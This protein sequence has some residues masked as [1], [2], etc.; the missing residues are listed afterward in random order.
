MAQLLPYPTDVYT[1]ALE[2]ALL[3]H[4][5][6]NLLHEQGRGTLPPAAMGLAVRN[7]IISWAG[8]ALEPEQRKAFMRY[9]QSLH[10]HLRR[11][12]TTYMP[13]PIGEPGPQSP[14]AEMLAWHF[15]SDG[16]ATLWGAV[17]QAVAVLDWQAGRHAF[18]GE[19]KANV[20]MGAYSKGPHCGICSGTRAHPSFCRLVNRFINHLCPQLVWTSFALNLDTRMPPHRDQGNAPTGSL[21]TCLTHN[22]GGELWLE[23]GEGQCYDDTEVGMRCGRIVR[24]SMQSLLFPAHAM[25]HCTCDWS[26]TNRVT[27]AAYCIGTVKHLKKEETLLL[28]ELGFCLPK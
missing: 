2:E 11:Y 5:A 15:L 6:I 1:D 23:D 26:L 4:A 13:E 9:A 7:D 14:E 12:L 20:T 18:S 21:L 16:S 17:R 10:R 28:E 25:T 22:E 27:L 8:Q 24:L 3:L 19:R